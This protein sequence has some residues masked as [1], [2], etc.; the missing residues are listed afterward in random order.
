M[1]KKKKKYSRQAVPSSSVAKNYPAMQETPRCGFYPWVRK[2]PQK[3]KW[4]ATPVILPVKSHG[5]RSL[6]G[7]SPWSCKRVGHD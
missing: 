1:G 4:Q 3:R 2:I 7:Y 5:Q 6:M